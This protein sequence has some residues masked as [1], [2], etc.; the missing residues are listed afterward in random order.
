MSPRV[1]SKKVLVTGG[2]GFIGSHLIKHLL[3][4]GHEVA[5]VDNLNDYYDVSLKRAR[6]AQFQDDITFFACDMAE[7]KA[8]EDVFKEIRPDI[9]CHLAAQAGVRYSLTHP[10]AYIHSNVTGSYNIFHLSRD[11][12]VERV[13]YASTSSVYGTSR[14]LPFK[15]DQP[16]GTP[17]SIYA[18]TKKATELFA[19]TFS[20]QYNLT[21]IGFRFFSVYGEW[22]RPDMALF[23]FTEKILKG[24]PIQ[25]FNNGQLRRDFTYVGDIVDGFTRGLD[26]ETTGYNIY[27]I[28]NGEPQELMRYIDVIEEAIGKKAKKEFLPMQAGDIEAS[29]A[30][31]TKATKELGYRSSVSIDEG[32][33]RFVEWYRGYYGV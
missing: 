23:L 8:L 6:L 9:V 13:L 33:P 28:G 5:C 24:E 32:I 27:N 19:H 12:E 22:G 10:E 3:K 18:A 7:M 26:S 20:D 14:S 30:D 16:T 4:Q 17:R 11:Y 15:E 21:T 1:K 2:A 25:V 31:I 29:H